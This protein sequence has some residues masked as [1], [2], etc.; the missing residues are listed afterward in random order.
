MADLRDE[1]REWFRP[2][3]DDMVEE[4]VDVLTERLERLLCDLEVDAYMAGEH[5]FAPYTDRAADERIRAAL[6]KQKE[7]DN[8]LS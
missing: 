5:S 2:M 3:G 6:A 8:G 1:I 4:D 7:R